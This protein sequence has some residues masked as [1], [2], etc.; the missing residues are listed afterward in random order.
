MHR[1][2]TQEVMS[3]DWSRRTRRGVPSGRTVFIKL[4]SYSFAVRR[5]LVS[6]T[7]TA[8]NQAPPGAEAPAR[9]RNLKPPA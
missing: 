3:G 1:P 5:Q 9:G 6:R 4:E 2:S 8:E 7:T